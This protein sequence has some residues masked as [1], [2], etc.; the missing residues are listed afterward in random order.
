MFVS[1][2]WNFSNLLKRFLV[3]TKLTVIFFIYHLQRHIERSLHFFGHIFNIS[4]LIWAFESE[5]QMKFEMMSQNQFNL[6]R[7]CICVLSWYHDSCA[8]YVSCDKIFNIVC[9]SDAS[10]IKMYGNISKTDDNIKY[11]LHA[12]RCQRKRGGNQSWQNLKSRSDF[13]PTFC[14]PTYSISL[15][16]IFFFIYRS[17]APWN[18]P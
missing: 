1:F 16:F 2:S 18:L 3:L 7:W 9:T 14:S 17:L 4:P 12:Y 15:H 13:S 5:G 8:K 10:V 6:F 11:A